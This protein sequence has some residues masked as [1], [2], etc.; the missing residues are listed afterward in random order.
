MLKLQEVRY[1][2]NDQHGF[3][4]LDEE[5]RVQLTFFWWDGPLVVTLPNPKD[6][7][8]QMQNEH[9]RTSYAE[10]LAALPDRLAAMGYE[11]DVDAILGLVV[12]KH[13]AG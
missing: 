6:P 9:H 11:D 13:G 3:Q 10:V 1:S 12:K 5:G 2:E 4:L 8:K 7:K